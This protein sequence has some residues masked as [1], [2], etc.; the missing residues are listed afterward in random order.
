MC[1]HS[2]FLHDD[3]FA[4]ELAIH[5]DVDVNVRFSLSINIRS[6]QAGGYECSVGDQQFQFISKLGLSQHKPVA[7]RMTMRQGFC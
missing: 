1:E 2:C 7:M 3:F 4:I 5:H 6:L